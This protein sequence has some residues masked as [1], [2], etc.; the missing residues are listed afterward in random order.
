[1]KNRQVEGKLCYSRS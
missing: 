1:M